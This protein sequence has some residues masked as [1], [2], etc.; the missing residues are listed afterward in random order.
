MIEEDDPL[1]H[2]NAMMTL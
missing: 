2:F 1:T